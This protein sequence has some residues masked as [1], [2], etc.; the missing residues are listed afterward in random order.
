ML[1]NGTAYLCGR[2]SDTATFGAISVVSV[3]QQDIFLARIDN[4]V[5]PLISSA[6]EQLISTHSVSIYPNPTSGHL[7]I[8]LSNFPVE[9]RMR[10]RISDVSGTAAMNGTLPVNT[11]V[12]ELDVSTL[13]RGVYMLRIIGSQASS[14]SMFIK[15]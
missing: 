15:Q 6:E 10:Y 1:S 2:F 3:G 13:T 9:A 5:A 7:S 12:A 14:A 11:Q 4:C 8:G